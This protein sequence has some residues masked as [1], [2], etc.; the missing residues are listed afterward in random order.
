M[1]QW[2]PLPA[3]ETTP[4]N[5]VTVQGTNVSE[6]K[7]QTMTSSNQ[8]MKMPEQEI[9]QQQGPQRKLDMNTEPEKRWANFLIL[10]DYLPKV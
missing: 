6:S 4:T 3:K 9:V 1:E 2:P 8:T 7:V 5:N 10:I